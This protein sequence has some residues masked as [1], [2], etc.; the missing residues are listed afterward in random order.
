MRSRLAPLSSGQST[1]ALSPF[2]PNPASASPVCCVP[3]VPRSAVLNLDI[4]FFKYK[5]IGE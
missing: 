2:T 5:E 3:N 4:F 1:P